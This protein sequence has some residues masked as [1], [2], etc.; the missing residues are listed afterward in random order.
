[1][2]QLKEIKWKN[3]L[4]TPLLRTSRFDECSEIIYKITEEKGYNN[5]EELLIINHNDFRLSNNI[6]KPFEMYDRVNYAY[7][8][9]FDMQ[10]SNLAVLDIDNRPLSFIMM[11]VEQLINHHQIDGI[12]VVQSS[13][14]PN[15]HIYLSLIKKYDINPFYLKLREVNIVCKGFNNCAIYRNFIII[16]V[17]QK[18]LGSFSD[19]KT[20]PIIKKC[21]RKID[22][23]WWQ[24][25]PILDKPLE[26]PKKNVKFSLRG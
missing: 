22:E 3:C 24:L 13:D 26:E 23:T 15:W 7:G 18:F 16:R 4:S 6:F 17:S 2:V 11:A 21:F 19:K 25:S 8:L 14:K 20:I 12:D 10:Y 5:H 9:F 1:M